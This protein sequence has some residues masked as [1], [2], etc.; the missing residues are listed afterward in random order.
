M[1]PKS[2]LAE[3]LYSISAGVALLMTG[4]LIAVFSLIA[5]PF[6][7]LIVAAPLLASAV[8]LIVASWRAECP[9]QGSG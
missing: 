8:F 6:I 1:N 4:A 2:C 7:G 9:I 3:R 5:L